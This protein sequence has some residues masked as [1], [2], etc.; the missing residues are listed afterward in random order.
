MDATEKQRK[1]AS[2]RCLVAGTARIVAMALASEKALLQGL[3][4]ALRRA[5]RKAL[6][7]AFV[8]ALRKASPTGLRLIPKYP[9][10]NLY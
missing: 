4:K 9:D 10:L 7:K 1:G 5:L 6:V 3:R 2:P 8:K